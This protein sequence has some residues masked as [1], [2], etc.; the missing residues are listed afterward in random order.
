M[1]RVDYTY[2]HDF[3]QAFMLAALAESY[4][5]GV[6]FCPCG[7]AV[8]NIASLVAAVCPPGGNS[9]AQ[10]K[11]PQQPKARCQ[12]PPQRGQEPPRRGK[13]RER[14]ENLDV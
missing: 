6:A 9:R 3:A 8:C 1:L 14:S 7:A 2:L 10:H 12:Q 13:A 11:K 5:C 4:P